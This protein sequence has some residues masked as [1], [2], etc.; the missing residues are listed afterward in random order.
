M[1][2]KIFPG[3]L[4]QEPLT[5]NQISFC[6]LSHQH[7]DTVS[8]NKDP[9]TAEA[10]DPFSKESVSRG[11]KPILLRHASAEKW[12]QRVVQSFLVNVDFLVR[13]AMTDVKG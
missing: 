10:Y 9:S 7:S 12:K 2:K 11:G 1:S 5:R 3:N 4:R 8:M 13:Y 6:L